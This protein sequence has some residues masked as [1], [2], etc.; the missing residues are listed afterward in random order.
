VGISKTLMPYQENP[1]CVKFDLLRLSDLIFLQKGRLGSMRNWDRIGI[2][3]SLIVV[4]FSSFLYAET[5]TPASD[6]DPV[7]TLWI[8]MHD[9]G[10]INDVDLQSALTT[11]RLPAGSTVQ[12]SPIPKENQPAITRLCEQKVISAQE[13]AYLFFKGQIPEMT[14]DETKAFQD[15]AKVYQPDRKKRLTYEVRRA[16]QKVE[17]IRLKKQKS[18]EWKQ[19]HDEAIIRATEEGLEIK[20]VTAKGQA[21]EL[22]AYDAHGRAIYNT[23][24]NRVSAQTIGTDRSRPGGSSPFNL[25]GTNITIAVWDAGSAN[26]DHV[27]FSSRV[28]NGDTNATVMDHPTMVAGTL[29]AAGIDT[30]AQ[31]MAYSANIIMHDWNNIIGEMSDMAISSPNIQISNHSYDILCGWDNVNWIF[32]Y[33]PRWWGDTRLSEDEDYQFG[34]YSSLSQEMDEFCYTAPYHLPIFAAGNDRQDANFGGFFGYFGA[35]NSAHGYYDYGLGYWNF[36]MRVRPPD[37]GT[38]GLDCI[39]PRGV[40][41]NILTVGAVVDIPGGCT[42]ISD[43][44]LEGYSATGPTDDGRIKPDIIA[45]GQALHTTS[46]DINDVSNNTVYTD[47]SGTSFAAPSVAGSLALLQELHER[48]YGTNSPML[49]STYKALVIHTA[50]DAYNPGPDYRT[51]WGL[52]NTERAGWVI[53]NNAAWNSLPHIK[54]VS[55]ADGNMVQFG[56]MATTG[57]PL[58]VTIA[59]TDPAGPEAPWAL[60][61]TN[62]T[63]VNDLDLR[64]ISPDGVTTNC[65]WILDPTQPDALAT[66]GDNF[67]DNVEQVLINEPTNG[68][69]TVSVTHKGSL[70]NGVQDVSIIITGNT[71]TNAPDFIVTTMGALGD[72]DNPSE[73]NGWIQLS[74]AGV[75]G[76]LYQMESNTN[77]L[78]NGGW[79]NHTDIISANLE[80]M[81]YTDTN[82]PL[83][84]VRFYR[85]ERLK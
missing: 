75:V 29:G 47:A 8:K 79:S 74:W 73:T 58:K 14:V 13:L 9:A 11:G 68:C 78:E 38:N 84:V 67:R 50:D 63:L 34:W 28:V 44:N 66:N 40:S 3:S 62:L 42:N 56:V 35:G 4:V 72:G 45:N 85:V 71:P 51:G 1:D 80:S 60:N 36:S 7:N 77:L 69:Y 6:T 33:Y 54:E 16:H 82:A 20:G 22:Q 81:Q 15:L 19:K 55:L 57:T 65:P 52:M 70:S 24:F 41:K 32:W 59:W 37:G 30:N 31:G 12:N 39:T 43:I 64:V 25:T 46:Y 27:E 26:T 10:M 83:D 23:T 49:A 2:L 5:V 76:G 61:P 48:F 17:L 53:T 18:Q 21:Y